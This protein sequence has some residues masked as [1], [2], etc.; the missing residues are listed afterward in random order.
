MRRHI[1]TYAYLL[2]A[3]LLLLMLSLQG[4]EMDTIPLAFF[5]TDFSSIL[6]TLRTGRTLQNIQFIS[7][8]WLMRKTEMQRGKR[9]CPIAQFVLAAV[10]RGAP[11]YFNSKLNYFFIILR[12]PSLFICLIFINFFKVPQVI[13]VNGRKRKNKHKQQEDCKNLIPPSRCNYC[14]QPAFLSR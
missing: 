2:F 6:H 11:K 12:N 10:L 7:I 5:L 1:L 13:C 8:M 9:I 4:K 14:L 3:F